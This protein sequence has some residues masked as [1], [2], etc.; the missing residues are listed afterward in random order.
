M[1]HQVDVAA[2]TLRPHWGH[3]LEIDILSLSY[4]ILVSVRDAYGL[5]HFRWYYTPGDGWYEQSNHENNSSDDLL[6]RNTSEWSPR[7]RKIMKLE[8]RHCYLNEQTRLR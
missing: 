7:R 6:G 2:N 8:S 4:P 1:R 5:G 3:G